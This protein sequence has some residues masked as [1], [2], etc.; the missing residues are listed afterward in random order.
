MEEVSP[1]ETKEIVSKINTAYQNTL[2]HHL[3]EKDF[4]FGNS[5]KGLLI[6]IQFE[7]AVPTKSNF[8]STSSYQSYKVKNYQQVIDIIKQLDIQKENTEEIIKAMYFNFR[9]KLDEKSF[10]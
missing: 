8:Y 4:L 7:E 3:K 1:L 2:K 5:D 10:S 6:T 9:K